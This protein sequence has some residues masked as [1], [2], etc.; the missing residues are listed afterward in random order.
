M[1]KLFTFLATLA[2]LAC[3]PAP[4]IG[5]GLTT[6]LETLS[7]AGGGEATYHLGMIHHLGLEGRPKDA[8]KAFE[9]FQ[10]ATKRGDP[11]GAYK[12][13]CFYD[14]QGEGVVESDAQL[15]LRYKMVAAE[16]GYS[17]AQ[18][19]VARHLFQDGRVDD[20]LRWLEKAAAQGE[21]TALMALAGLYSGGVPNSPVPADPVKSYAYTML[22]FVDAPTEF[23]KVKRKAEAELKAKLTSEQLDAA[24]SMVRSWR[25]RASPLTDKANS[26]LQA[27]KALSGS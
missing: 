11:L 20:A 24:K 6:K 18:S 26:G 25:V 16:A 15:A 22:M 21:T 9:L 5:S 27:A 2:L 23:A 3:A 10:L 19:D 8:R 13:G 14:G 4:A 12:L 1:S 7:N 17:R